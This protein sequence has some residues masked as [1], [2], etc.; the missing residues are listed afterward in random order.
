MDAFDGMTREQLLAVVKALGKQA[1]ADITIRQVIDLYLT[2]MRERVERNDLD[3]D[4]VRNIK[5]DLERFATAHGPRIVAE[6]QQHHVTMFLRSNPAW[7][8]AHAQ[9]AVSGHICTCFRW[10]KEQG[11]IP[12]NPFRRIRTRV[13]QRSRKPVSPSEYVAL[14]RHGHRALRRILYFLRKTGCRTSEARTLKWADV[15]LD[16]EVP[17]VRLVIHKTAKATGKPRLFALDVG[18][19]RFL[20]ALKRQAPGHVDNVFFNSNG[21]AWDRRALALAFRRTRAIAGLSGDIEARI[22]A[23]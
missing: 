5:R 13:A 17:H 2:L 21:R 15:H 18:T 10:A 12:D 20:A 3:A 7:A 23:Y 8:S 1:S 16:E 9:R 11:L 19:V 14:M 6:S 4:Y 22:S